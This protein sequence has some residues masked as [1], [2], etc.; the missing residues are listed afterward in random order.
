MLYAYKVIFLSTLDY[1]K[2]YI[3]SICQNNTKTDC[4]YA[5][6]VE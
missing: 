4:I 6:L 3:C 1:F 5:Y 2:V